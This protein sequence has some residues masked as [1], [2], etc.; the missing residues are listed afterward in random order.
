MANF[1]VHRSAIIQDIKGS[2]LNKADT[3]VAYY[4]FDFRNASKQSVKDLIISLLIQLASSESMT[5][6]AHSILKKLY[7]EHKAGMDEAG[8]KDLRNAL[9]KVIS[10]PPWN[11]IMIIIDALDEMKGEDIFQSF[12]DFMQNLHDEEFSYLHVLITSR[13][14][15]PIASSLRELCSKTLGVIM[16]DKKDVDADVETF[17]DYILNKHHGFQNSGSTLK[18]Q[19][20]KALLENANGM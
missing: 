16:V 12:L 10:L 5:S 8:L 15:I 9:L 3:T 11:H 6:A 17:L 7:D 13:P 4:F 1:S 18:N 19:I 2:D 20:K 14:L